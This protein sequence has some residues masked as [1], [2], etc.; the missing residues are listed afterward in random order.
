MMDVQKLAGRPI[1][2]LFRACT[3]KSAMSALRAKA[4]ISG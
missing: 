4:D 2:I 3:H 1:I